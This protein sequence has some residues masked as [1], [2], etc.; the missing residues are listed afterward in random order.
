MPTRV[1]TAAALDRRWVHAHVYTQRRCVVARGEGLPVG[2]ERR[3]SR[4]CGVPRWV[5]MGCGQ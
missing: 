3:V 5:H 2:K 4:V 1:C